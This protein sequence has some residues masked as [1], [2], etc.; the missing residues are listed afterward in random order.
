MVATTCTHYWDIDPAIGPISRGECRYC[1]AERQFI[2][3]LPDIGEEGYRRMPTAIVP[4]DYARPVAGTY[5]L[6]TAGWAA[7]Y[8]N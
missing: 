4:A 7:V 8:D 6:R 1:G 3:R 2:N 5:R